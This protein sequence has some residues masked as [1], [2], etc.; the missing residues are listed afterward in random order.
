MK[1]INSIILSIFLV[2]SFSAYA[3][4]MN[5]PIGSWKT[6]D[7]L[8]GTTKSIVEISE[9]SN[10]LLEGKVAKLF[11]DPTKTCPKCKGLKKNQ[12]VLGL[13]VIE[14]LQRTRDNPRLWNG[15]EIL[16][17]KNGQTYHCSL[18]VIDNGHKLLVR[19]YIGM[20]LFGRSQTWVRV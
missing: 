6:V 15:G 7:D 11:V 12:P 8:T 1:K 16:D 13:R 2:I 9:T 18:E 5:S 14:N 3:A 10:Q 20:P 19:G 17:P 4:D